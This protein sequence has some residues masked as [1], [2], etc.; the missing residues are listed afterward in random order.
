[1]GLVGDREML[2]LP[3]I[4]KLRY[5]PGLGWITALNRVETEIARKV[6]KVV[7]FYK[8]GKHLDCKIGEV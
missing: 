3:Q 6:G 4:G 5:R 1:M 8:M 2:T 7:G